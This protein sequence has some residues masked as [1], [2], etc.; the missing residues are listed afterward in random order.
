[1]AMRGAGYSD[2]ETLEVIACVALNV[3]TN[4][5]NSVA[6]PDVD[7]PAVPARAEALQARLSR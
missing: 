5:F 1:M 3:F 6:E 2:A 4:M 7:F